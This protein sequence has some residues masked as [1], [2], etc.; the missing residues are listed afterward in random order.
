VEA[1][2]SVNCGKTEKGN[3]SIGEVLFGKSEIMRFP[4]ILVRVGVE[5]FTIEVDSLLI[6]F[7]QHFLVSSCWLMRKRLFKVLQTPISINLCVVHME[8]PN[9]INSFAWNY[10]ETLGIFRKN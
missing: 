10:I 7:N 4:N 5:H 8:M 6:T 3:E 2:Y 1:L 9:L